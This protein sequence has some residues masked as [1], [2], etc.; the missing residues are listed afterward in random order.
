MNISD[1]QIENF[2]DL[3]VEEFNEQISSDVGRQMVLRILTI[4]V[5]ANNDTALH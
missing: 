1:N 3:Y 5:H 2:V 4:L